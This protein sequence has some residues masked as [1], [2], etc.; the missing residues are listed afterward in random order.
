LVLGFSGFR[1]GH[2]GRKAFEKKKKK[3]GGDSSGGATN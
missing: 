2:R 3:K 1:I